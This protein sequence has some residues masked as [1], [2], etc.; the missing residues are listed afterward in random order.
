MGE[1]EKQAM[2]FPIIWHLVAGEFIY[3]GSTL[4]LNLFTLLSCIKEIVLS[5]RYI[6]LPGRS[7]PQD[8]ANGKNCNIHI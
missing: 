6:G 3:G 1:I 4:F 7:S 8:R 5:C 2:G